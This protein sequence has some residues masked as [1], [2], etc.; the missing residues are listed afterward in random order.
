MILFVLGNF[1]FLI[2]LFYYYNLH[3]KNYCIVIER[4]AVRLMLCLLANVTTLIF[5]VLDYEVIFLV[6]T[7]EMYLLV[8][9]LDIFNGSL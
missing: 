5:K 3:L 2:F 9:F 7:S 8:L 1:F 4:A 6:G